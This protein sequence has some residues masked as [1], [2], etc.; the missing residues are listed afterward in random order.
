MKCLVEE[1]RLL[2]KVEAAFVA[3]FWSLERCVWVLSNY[4]ESLTVNMSSK[5][6][7]DGEAIDF[8][9]RRIPDCIIASPSVPEDEDSRL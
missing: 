6:K 5:V 8:C 3:A 7:L 2:C 4:K 9:Q 1:R